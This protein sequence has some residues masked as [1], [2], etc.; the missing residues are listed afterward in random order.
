MIAKFFK[1]AL[2]GLCILFAAAVAVYAVSRHW[3]I[4]EAQRQ[5]LAQLRQPLPPLRGSNMFG[6]LWSLSYAIPEAQRETVLAQDVER[7][8]RLPDRVPFQSTAAG[9]P[10]L[11]RW[12]STAPALCTASAGGC[13]QRVRED[14]QAYADALVTQAP[15]LARMRALANYAD[16]RSPFRSRGDTPLPE[17]PR[18]PLSMTASALDF[19][20]GRTTQALSGV[21]TDAQVARVLMRSSD[22]LAITMIGA[23]MLRGNAQLFA[24]MLAE[25]PAQQS[26]PMHCAAAFA[27]ATTQ[28]ISLCHA[29]HGESRMV[30]SLLQ[31]APAPHDRG[32]LERVGPQLL[33]G[34]RTQALLAPT[35]TWACSAPVLAVLAQDQAL[36]QDSVPVPE[37][38]SVTCVANASGCLLASVSRPDYANYQ[39]KLQ[40][41]AAALRTVSTML[42]LRDH[43]ADA[44]PLTQR[45]AALPLA[46][47]GQTR[48]LQVDGDG[49]HLILAQYAR[50]EDGAAEYRWPLPASRITEQ[51]QANAIQ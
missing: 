18:M 50:R 48:P 43:P 24:D 5:A 51:R 31:D 46:L 30:F 42:W 21:C 49:K 41:T 28:E 7:F 16:Y 2:L 4:P 34:E 25:L 27:P 32:W 40:D 11:P 35:F 19:V 10:R 12:P 33:D 15:M 8:N 38:T 14:P 13:V 26:L 36:P 17:L 20:Q 1:A 39:H 29:L 9:Y 3:P 45:L 37:T 6:A 22:N 23:A 47:R 44:T